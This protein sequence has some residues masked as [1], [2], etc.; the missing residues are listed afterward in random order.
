MVLAYFLAAVLDSSSLL[1]PVHTIFPE[2]KT[3]AVVLGLLIFMMAAAN[4]FG[5]YSVFLAFN[6]IFFRSSLHFRFTVETMF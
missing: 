3:K 2:E 4:R 6:A 5:L 1:A